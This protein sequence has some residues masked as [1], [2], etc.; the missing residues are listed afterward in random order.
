MRLSPKT[1]K[2]RLVSPDL[3]AM[4]DVVF[5]LIIFF[6]TTSSFVKMTRAE[7]QLTEAPGESGADSATPGLVINIESD[8]VYV[9]DGE[10]IPFDRL[11]AMI[12]VEI[13]KVG[14]DAQSLDVV[15][16]A[17]RSAGLVHINRLAQGMIDRG[18]RSWRLA[19]QV[20]PGAALGGG[21]S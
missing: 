14:G 20:P 9:V 1:S 2:E 17:D 19:T 10:D 4:V 21:R 7:L 3:T 6:V 11:M 18:V 13:D 5:L 15:V 16:R 12:T 8:G